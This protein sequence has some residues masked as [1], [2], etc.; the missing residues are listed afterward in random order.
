MTIQRYVWGEG[1][2][3]CQLEGAGLMSHVDLKIT[4]SRVSVPIFPYVTYQNL[5]RSMSHV[6][7]FLTQYSTLA[8]V[9]SN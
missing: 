8:Y 1:K 2:C 7:L 6:A 3:G 5:K 4:T 9:L